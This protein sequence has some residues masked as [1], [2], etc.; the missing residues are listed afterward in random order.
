RGGEIA[1]RS[2]Y[3]PPRAMASLLRAIVDDP[4][5]GPSVT[6]APRLALD[7]GAATLAPELRAR[8]E[9]AFR[10]SYDAE[11]GG[12]GFGHKYL[13]GPSV[14]L[15]TA[16]AV[17]GDAR[18]AAMS[19][20]T[21]DAALALIDPVDGGLYQYSTGGV[22]TEP[23]FEKLMSFQAEGMAA[24]ARAFVTWDEPAYEK[25]AQAIHRF[26]RNTLASAD[27]AFFASQDADVVPGEHAASYFTLGEA[28]RRQRGIPRVDEHRYARENGWAIRA[29]ATLR[30]STGDETALDEAVRAARWVVANRSLPGGGFRHDEVDEAGPYL[31]D[32]IAMG[33]AFLALH[34]ATA[35]REWLVNAEDAS[36]FIARVFAAPDLAAGFA[37]VAGARGPLAPQLPQREENAAVAR[38]EN[39]LFR[40]TGD[41]AHRDLAAR[42]MRFLS[43]PEIAERA[44]VAAALLAD[45]EVSA[46]PAHVTVVGPKS[47]ATARSLFL[48]A[49][50]PAISYARVEWWDPSEGPRPASD[51]EL[52][53]LDE[54]VAFVCA[55][56]RCSQPLTTA[57]EIERRLA[58]FR[59]MR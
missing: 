52:P 26:L 50:R 28:E 21:L 34:Q 31:G 12:F 16:R 45:R 38:F 10:A 30:A 6:D 27:G 14:E 53:V 22:W 4:T 20:G 3:V 36:R 43:A 32:T 42:A 11:R 2:G 23:H 40:M 24:Y 39:L 44:P 41:V 46:E 19:R 54:P 57:A 47:S 56:G 37:T 29:L 7:A 15:A 8:L 58:P 9:Q 51:V 1:K 13:D 25:A 59:P 17:D 48:A 49:L 5:P 18:S 33:Q 55:D 35:D